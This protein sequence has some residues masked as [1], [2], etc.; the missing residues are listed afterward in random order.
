MTT[1]TQTLVDK[2]FYTIRLVGEIK[3][4]SA[5]YDMSVEFRRAAR[6]RNPN[7]KETVFDRQCAAVEVL[8]ED[9]VITD[10]SLYMCVHVHRR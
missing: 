8:R 7:N 10:R 9:N 2:S 3:N 4:R 6:L 1:Q 5:E